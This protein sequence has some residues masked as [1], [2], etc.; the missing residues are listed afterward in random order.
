MSKDQDRVFFGHPGGLS[1]LFFTEMWERLS[2][3][4]ARAFLFVYMTTAVSKGG[5]GMKAGSAG[6]VM[7]LYMSSVYLLSLPGGWIADRFVGQRRAVTLGGIGIMLGNLCL[8]LPQ[9]RDVV[10]PQHPLAAEEAHMPA[11]VCHL[12]VGDQHMD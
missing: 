7:A 2:Y 8:A 11:A 1:T 4:G 12:D 5:L 3:Y 9:R 6:L 10:D